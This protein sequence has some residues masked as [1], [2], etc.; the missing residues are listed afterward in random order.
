M[1]KKF[2]VRLMAG[3]EMLIKIALASAQTLQTGVS[4]SLV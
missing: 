1:F 4:V 3:S 2:K